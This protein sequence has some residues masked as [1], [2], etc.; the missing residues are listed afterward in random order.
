MK[1]YILK[2][3]IYNNID[4]PIG[5]IVKVNNPK[6]EVEVVEGKLKGEKG[7]IADGVKGFIVDDTEENRVLIQQCI[8]HDE[9][10]IK[11][12]KQNAKRIKSIPNTADF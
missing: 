9:N 4:F 2:T 10:L 8:E 3:A 11:Q 6:W 12:L 1:T 7:H 5:T